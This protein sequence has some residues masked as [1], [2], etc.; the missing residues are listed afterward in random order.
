MDQSLLTKSLDLLYD[1]PK[2]P[3]PFRRNTT[4]EKVKKVAAIIR[5]EIK[6]FKGP[7][8]SWPPPSNEFLPE[9]IEI[10]PLLYTLLRELLTTGTENKRTSRL[11]KSIVQDILYNSSNGRIKTM[12]QLKLIV[13]KPLHLKMKVKMLVYKIMFQ[14]MYNPHPLLP[15]YM[16]IATLNLKQSMQKLC[17]ALMGSL[18]KEHQNKQIISQ[19]A[20][21]N[22]CKNNNLLNQ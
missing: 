4:E 1:K 9:N 22:R 3:N 11:V 15:L 5:D 16:I 10:P 18:Y 20:A 7:F 8:S 6:D 14:I 13:L 17:T 19:Y 21:Q 2:E 12:K